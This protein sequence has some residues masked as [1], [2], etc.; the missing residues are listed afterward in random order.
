MY[1]KNIHT[2]Y[3]KYIR[4]GKNEQVRNFYEKFQFETILDDGSQ[5]HYKL[6]H[7]KFIFNS[8]KYISVLWKNK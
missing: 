2:V 3:G 7:N 1:E 6:S 8:L 5:K 4:T